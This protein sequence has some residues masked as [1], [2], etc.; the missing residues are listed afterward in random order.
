MST[1]STHNTASSHTEGEISKE[2]FHSLLESK[3]E[4]VRWRVGKEIYKTPTDHR[5]ASLASRRPEIL[6]SHVPAHIAHAL[7]SST[8]NMCARTVHTQPTDSKAVTYRD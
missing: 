5:A 6:L 2:E 4:L 1:G 8:W 7:P 3:G